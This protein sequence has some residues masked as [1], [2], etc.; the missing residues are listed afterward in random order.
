MSSFKLNKL[1][2]MSKKPVDSAQESEANT[3]RLRKS[4]TDNLIGAGKVSIEIV[5]SI[6]EQ[7][8]KNVDNKILD[9]FVKT[10]I[11]PSAANKTLK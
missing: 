9:D 4:Q 2:Q 5:G 11:K 1:K 7:L 6:T 3:A 10:R 8:Q